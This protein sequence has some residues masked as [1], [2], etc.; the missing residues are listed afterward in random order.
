MSAVLR[1]LFVAYVAL[2]ALHIGYV[3]LHEPFAFDAWN[4][5]RDT[6]GQPFSI[7]NWLDYGVDQYTHSN[8]RVGQWFTYLAYKLEYFAVIAT[9]LAY[10]ALSLAVTVLGLGRWPT[11]KRG[12]DLALF[13]ITLGVTWFALPRV[14]MIIFCRAYGANYLYGAVIQLWFLVVLRLRPHGEGS[15]AACVPYWLLG[16]LA[17]A[18]N[19]HTGP[20]LV[21]FTL[22]YAAWRYRTSEAMPKLALSG[23]LGVV[24]GF[25]MI[26]FAPGQGER[27]EGL[28]TRVSLVGRLLQ[29]GITGNL[30]IVQDYLIAAAPIV[31]L[32][33][34]LLVASARDPDRD[35]MRD[36]LWRFGWALVAGAL[37]TVTLFVSPKL[38]PRMFL[39]PC[40]LLVAAFVGVADA[41]LVT[42]KRLAPVV[43]LAAF[44]SVY[45]AARSIPQYSRLDEASEVRM[46]ALDVSKPGTVVTIDAYPHIE[47]SWWFL[48]DDFRNQ[49]KR[50]MVAEYFGL[51]DIVFRAT[52]LEAPL[53]VSDVRFTPIYTL[54]PPSCLDESG[55]FQLGQIRGL[56]IPS[57]QRAARSA[58]ERLR[59]RIGSKGRIDQLDIAVDFI[60][61]TPALPRPSLL[62]GRW[63]DD[64]FEAYGG[65]IE[66][67]GSSRTRLVQVPKDLRVS[68]VDIF[69]YSVGHDWKELGKGT[70]PR[71]AYTPWR[72]G[73]Y[74]AL[75]CKG[76]ECFVIAATRML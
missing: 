42:S 33:L 55:G 47:D 26:F 3:M 54:T 27:Y 11:W 65:L 50:E 22:S 64:A 8:P 2:T 30:D 4:V 52:D 53:G 63:K 71:L 45:A 23:A 32:T 36:P 40:A 58:I 16:V 13:A 67:D 61:A 43:V 73:T 25:A 9:P 12:Q 49:N 15:V 46:H 51:R 62:L 5:A 44:A 59:T 20:T 21:I 7:G 68:T 76:D 37:I 34:I 31:G 29:R 70:S 39:L 69:I 24:V 14:G 75:A 56:D 17:G 28:G 6:S 19:E 66:R 60:G 48:G 10:L 35:G 57:T 38:G 1:L 74:W 72:E 18:S 41:V